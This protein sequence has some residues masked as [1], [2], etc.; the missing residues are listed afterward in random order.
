[1]TFLLIAAH[2]D[3]EILG[4]GTL[5]RE[6]VEAVIFPNDP[7]QLRLMESESLASVY[8]YE[9]FVGEHPEIGDRDL[10]VP[11]PTERHP[12][13]QAALTWALTLGAR[14][15]QVYEYSIEK[16]ATYAV[17]LDSEEVAW[18]RETFQR[19]FP[20]QVAT[21]LDPAYFLFGG[22][23]PL[24]PPTI[25]VTFKRIAFH[26]WDAAPPEVGYLAYP[27]RHVFHVRLSLLDLMH[28]DRALEFHLVQTW[29]EAFA[30][31]LFEASMSCEQYA[32][33]LACAARVRY[34]CATEVEVWEDG[35]NGAR[36][37][38]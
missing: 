21:T 6:D 1:V 22:V 15:E 12:E 5:L 16:R 24:A 19:F 7:G 38:V 29:A 3:D 36:V 9:V 33:E 10:L 20:S 26:S 11:S 13:H 25:S 37:R 23:A 30:A 27:H 17:P 31:E 4:V 28:H 32:R 8:Q 18:K 35:E 34:A 14:L 2:P